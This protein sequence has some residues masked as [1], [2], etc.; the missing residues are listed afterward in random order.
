MSLMKFVGP[1]SRETKD[2]MAVVGW[3]LLALAC[4]GVLGLVVLG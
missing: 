2:F 4:F 1:L 3:W